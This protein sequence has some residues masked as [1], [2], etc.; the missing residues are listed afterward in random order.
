VNVLTPGELRVARLAADGMANREIAEELYITVKTVEVHLS[1][2]FRKLGI[3][4]RQD[5]K[6]KLHST[7]PSRAP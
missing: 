1:N 3:G 6:G 2:S 5:L 4:R 7:D